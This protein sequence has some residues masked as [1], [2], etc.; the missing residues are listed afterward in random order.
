[1]IGAGWIGLETAAAARGAGARSPCWR[2][3]SCRCCACSARR[4]RQ[5][6]AGLHRRERRRPALRG[7]RRRDPRRRPVGRD[8]ASSSATAAWSRPTRGGRRRGDARTSTSP[9]SA[10]L[11]G[12][13]RRAR[14]R[15]PAQ[16]A[17]RTSSPS[18]DVANA[19]HPVLGRR[20]RVEHWANALHQPAVAAKAMLGRDAVYDRLPYFFTD[21]YDLGMEYIGLRRARTTTWWSAATSTAREFVALWPRRQG[22][23]AGMN[24]NVWDVTTGSA[25]SSWPGSRRTRSSCRPRQPDAA[26]RRRRAG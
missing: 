20:I 15:E 7:H 3:P 24:V 8:A 17:T 19:E 9:A 22:R 21:Q 10:G 4:W 6:F 18:G 12:R 1:M 5:V 23:S 14:R 2:A 25:T 13:Q 26:S 11:D 16:L